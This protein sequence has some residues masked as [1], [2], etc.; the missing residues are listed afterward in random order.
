MSR[1]LPL[2][3]GKVF[4]DEAERVFTPTEGRDESDSCCHV[5]AEQTVQR[6]Q[7]AAGVTDTMSG[8]NTRSE[9]LCR[10][11]GVSV[12]RHRGGA[13][14]VGGSDVM[15]ND[16]CGLTFPPC[17]FVSPCWDVLSRCDCASSG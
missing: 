7:T 8:V 15:L 9:P 5:G 10:G 4:L 12:S 17:K 2:Q 16:E 13:D 1:V 14:P 11:V 6:L 3:T